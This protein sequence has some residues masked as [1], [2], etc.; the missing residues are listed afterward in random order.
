MNLIIF[1]S[2]IIWFFKPIKNSIVLLFTEIKYKKKYPTLKLS[3]KFKIDNTTFGKHN[4][5]ENATILNSKIDDFT[6]LGSDTH[7]NYCDVGKYTCIG[8]NVKIGLG[9]H[10][11]KDFISVHPIFYSPFSQLD[12]TFTKKKYFKEFKKTFIG[13]DTWIG[14]NVFIKSGVVI[15]NG[16]IIAAGSVVTKNVVPYSIVGGV[17]A[18]IIRMRF[19]EN[20][21]K[22]L[23][24]IEWWN[25]DIE[26]LKKNYKYMHNVNKLHYLK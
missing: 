22:E 20:E 16:A 1:K 18:K 3:G 21:I 8:P 7:V 11:I 25:K 9:E 4:Y 15:G 23:I 13:N 2:S 17:P 6:Y 5:I 24:K 12:I 26:W 19:N 14:A 10:P